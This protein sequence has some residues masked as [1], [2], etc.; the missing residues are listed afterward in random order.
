LILLLLHDDKIKASKSTYSIIAD[1]R[2]NSRYSR[3][4][5]FPHKED[6]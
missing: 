3:M 2:V 6:H 4:A 1:E 5:S